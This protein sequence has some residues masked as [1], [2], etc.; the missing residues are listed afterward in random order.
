MQGIRK[1]IRKSAWFFPS[2][3]LCLIYL[4]FW[5][6]SPLRRSSIFENSQVELRLIF[7]KVVSEKGRSDVN[8]VIQLYGSNFEEDRI[9]K[10]YSA[11]ASAASFW[12]DPALYLEEDG[13]L[14]RTASTAKL[15]RSLHKRKESKLLRSDSE[16]GS[17]SSKSTE[18]KSNT[19]HI[20][21]FVCEIPRGS[22]AKFEI[23]KDVTNN[24]IIIDTELMEDITRGEMVK[25][26]R[27][28]KWPSLVNYGSLPRTYSHP[29]VPDMY[30]HRLGD[31]DPLDAL[32]ICPTMEPCES[33]ELYNV[34]ILGALAMRD[35]NTTDWKIITL[36]EK[37]FNLPSDKLTDIANL[38]LNTIHL[39]SHQLTRRD[40]LQASSSQILNFE[41]SGEVINV[42]D[43]LDDA[44]NVDIGPIFDEGANDGPL[45]RSFIYFVRREIDDGNNRF[46]DAAKRYFNPLLSLLKIW[47]KQYKRP[48]E[49]YM[50]GNDEIVQLGGEPNRF[51]LSGKWVDASSAY[52]VVQVH[53][54]NWCLVLRPVLQGQ[55]LRLPEVGIDLSIGINNLLRLK[56][57]NDDCQL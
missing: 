5:S 28:Y 15:S 39:S 3:F 32:E 6:I 16:T 10:S 44:F 51:D 30:T 40:G 54:K 57:W 27:H 29:L 2:I 31:G 22:T 9:K 45:F 52:N 35:G 46:I 37:C 12:H 50:V 8:Q 41:E 4:F 19:N 14:Y 24:P 20:V 47:F 18:T 36:R 43:N 56:D 25:K 23:V 33:G 53:H 42:D 48:I 49:K 17:V 1:G 21:S 26:G 55:A 7:S 34:L 13:D 38:G 11:T